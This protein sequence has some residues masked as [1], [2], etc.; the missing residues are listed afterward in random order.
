VV[1]SVL[2]LLTLLP[3]APPATAA[4]GEPDATPLTVRLTQLTPAAIPAKGQVTLAGTV[5]NDSDETWIAVNVHPFVGSAPITTREELA[6]AVEIDP[7]ADVGSRLFQAG[8]FVPVGDIDAGETVTFTIS[9]PVAVLPKAPGVYWIGV[10]ALGQDSQGRDDVADGRARTFIPLVAKGSPPTSV[11][12]VVPVREAV[13]RDRAGRLLNTSAW[14]DSLTSTGR[15][16]RIA[17]FV[18]SAG[19]HPLTML[20]DP[21]VLDAVGDL[22]EDNPPISFGTATE[23]TPSESASPSPSR[24]GVRLEA[25]DRANAAAWMSQVTTAGRRHSVLGLGYADPDVAALIRQRSP[26]RALSNRLAEQTFSGLGIDAI[27]AVA[28]PGGWLDEGAVT[29]L[30]A[31]SMVLLSDHAD[32]GSRTMLETPAE[33]DVILTDQQTALGGPGPTPAL[34]ALALRQR[35]VADAAL[36]LREHSPDP[37]VVELPASWDPGSE[38][39][40]A[41]FFNAIDLPWLDQVALSPS[42]VAGAPT[43]EPAFDYPATQ[44]KL[45]LAAENVTAARKLAQT[46]TTLTQLL[47]SENDIAHDLAGVALNAVS[48]HARD[49]Q[50]EARLQVLDTDDRMR[51]RLGKVEVLGTDFVTLSGGSG[52]L[53]VTLVNGLE[54]PVVVGVQPRTSTGDVRVAAAEPVKMAPGERT[55]LRLKAKASTIGVTRVVLTPVTEEGTEFGTPLTFSLR[56]S[57]VGKTIWFVLI[58]FGALLVVMILRRIRRGLVEHRWKGKDR[59]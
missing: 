7:T 29:Q 18:T 11:A 53:A 40:L 4:E 55:V 41:D 58:G 12:M 54:Q 17:G 51:A 21:A 13:R 30:P 28:P 22:A 27:R 59:G 9:L 8:Q 46:A 42:T 10:H 32:P 20:V 37:L 38:W 47:R 6:A 52:T 25:G 1:I 36:R 57:Q 19:P 43:I 48:V 44:R 31:S 33:Q 5:T 26:L 16:G 34:D 49:D 39:Q 56:T 3:S 23:A 15:L 50:V 35:I 14:S 24:S 2:V 45:E